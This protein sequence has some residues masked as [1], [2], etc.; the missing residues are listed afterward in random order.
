M[1][2]RLWILTQRDQDATAILRDRG[3]NG[4]EV[5]VTIAEVASVDRFV[6]RQLAVDH[7]TRERLRLERA[8][9]R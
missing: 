3:V 4:F 6:T 9:W 8:G 2:E 1:D 7:A 5:Q